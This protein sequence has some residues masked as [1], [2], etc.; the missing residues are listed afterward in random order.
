M[1]KYKNALMNSV[2]YK[3]IK[4]DIDSGNLSHAY[5]V[6]SPDGE[7]VK[8]LFK[9]VASAV[10]CQNN[11][12]LECA[13]CQKIES[14]NNIDVNFVNLVE[15]KIT[16]DDINELVESTILAPRV[17]DRKL[18]FVHSAEQMNTI[19]QNK[20]LKTLEEPPRSV[21]IFLG[22]KNESAMLETIKSR[23]RAISLDLFDVNTIY[24]EIF[25]LTG[26]MELSRVA[27]AC[28]QG[29]LGKAEQ[30]ATSSEYLPVYDRAFGILRAV[31]KSKDVASVLNDKVFEK[32]SFP[33]ML[34]VLSIIFRDMLVSKT[35]RALVQSQHRLSDVLGLAEGYSALALSKIL[36]LINEERKKL[37]FNV[38]SISVAENLLLGIL[39]VKFRCR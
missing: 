3:S 33:A 19:A 21:I 22:V 31:V 20:L 18:Y 32:E 17:G 11:V 16:V 15:G 12:C 26:D 6:L 1:I 7:A 10:F 30:I 9:L 5:M 28:S 14:G 35:D 38:G 13:E 36:F 8:Q 25:A 39:E 23:V 37:N 4:A 24:D 34:D 29:M 2:A 27:A